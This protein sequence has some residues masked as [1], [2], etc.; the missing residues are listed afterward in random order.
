[1]KNF[2]PED[3]KRVGEVLK[4]MKFNKSSLSPSSSAAAAALQLLLLMVVLV[5]VMYLIVT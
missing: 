3:F 1:M 2:G 5:V 4:R